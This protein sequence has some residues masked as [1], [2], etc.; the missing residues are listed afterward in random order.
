MLSVQNFVNTVLCVVECIIS[1]LCNQP[2][3]LVVQV[4]STKILHDHTLQP[5]SVVSM[6]TLIMESTEMMHA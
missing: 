4:A 2:H 3:G 1:T 5:I 6:V